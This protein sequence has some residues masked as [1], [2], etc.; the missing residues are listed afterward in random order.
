MSGRGSRVRDPRILR[1]L[2]AKRAAE[3][4]RLTQQIAAINRHR[5]SRGRQDY[6][7]DM[8]PLSQ[9]V[10]ADCSTAECS[11]RAETSSTIARPTGASSLCTYAPVLK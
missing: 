1:T 2:A 4:E 10:A 9:L 5:H 11:T 3:N 7:T 6:L 8:V